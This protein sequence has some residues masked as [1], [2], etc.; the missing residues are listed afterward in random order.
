ME[1]IEKIEKVDWG[2]YSGS[3]WYKPEEV[4]PVLK[5]LADLAQKDQA[6]NIGHMVLSTIGND[7]AGTYY[8]AIESALDIVIAIAEQTEN[9]VSKQC[10]LGVLYDL[11]CFNADMEGY[12]KGNAQE[13]E[14][15]VR[16]KL[17]PY[18]L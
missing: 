14:K 2:R 6:E 12:S 9:L 5:R 1:I 4:A 8:P 7:H 16:N 11:T 18:E 17:T 10:A 15:W 13:L 3:P